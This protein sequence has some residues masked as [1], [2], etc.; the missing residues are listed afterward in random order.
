MILLTI[1]RCQKSDILEME[2]SVALTYK[3]DR[4]FLVVQGDSLYY[5]TSPA[6]F[7]LLPMLVKF[8]LLQISS[9]C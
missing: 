7:I 1:G 4:E 2:H 9:L 8:G 6:W 5:Q 3:G